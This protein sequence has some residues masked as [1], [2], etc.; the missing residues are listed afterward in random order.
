M[1]SQVDE[2]KKK[3]DIVEVINRLLPLKKRGRHYIAC[4]PFHQEK[5]P[6]FTVSPEMQIFK[7]FG[8]GKSGDVFTFVQ[9][10]NRIDFREALEELAK[11]AGIKLKN[12]FDEGQNKNKKKILEINGEVAKFYHYM[13]VAHP[14]GADAK[15][16]VLDRGIKIETIKQFGIG[17]CPEQTTLIIN[18]LKKKGFFEDE[19]IKTGTFGKSNYNNRLYDRFAGRLVF[20]LIDFRGQILGFSGRVLPGVKKEQ[21]KY[22]NSPETEIYHKSQMVFGLNLAKDTIRTD[23]TVIVVEGEFDMISPYQAGIKNIVAVKGTAFT[24]E[25]LQL[26]RRYAETLVLALDA[27]F[28]GNHA[29]IRSIELAEKLDFDIKVVDLL[30]KFKDPDEAV[31]DNPEWF[32]KRVEEAISIWDFIINSAINTYGVET[33]KGKKQIL[34]MVLPFISRIKSEVI[35]SDYLHK[36]ATMIGSDTDSVSRE[37]NKIATNKIKEMIKPV[38]IEKEVEKDKRDE[39]EENLLTLIMGAKNI[40]KVAKRVDQNLKFMTVKWK[41]IMEI[42]LSGKVDWEKPLEIVPDELKDQFAAIYLTAE[43]QEMESIHRKGEI[44]K[45]MAKLISIDLKKQINDS[46]QRVAKFEREN[47]EEE[48]EIAEKENVAA[49]FKLSKWQKL[50]K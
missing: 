11:T 36:L 6:S 17:Y 18:Y 30:G 49:L 33:N 43:Q 3:L 32:K 34:E 28:A 47:N 35:R 46:A 16:Y 42:L 41:K 13:L 20:P 7:C 8:C 1:D 19:M 21:A 4:C 40:T 39:M 5:T 22:I 9:E 31:R 45:M 26:L 12:N 48:L 44:D 2:I 10:F 27:D 29:A 38:A 23:N 25:Q 50:Q 24:E 14:L 15:K 37:M